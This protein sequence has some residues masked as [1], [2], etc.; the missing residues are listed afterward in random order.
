[1]SKTMREVGIYRKRFPRVS[2]TFITEPAL[3]LS[4][5]DPIFIA[6]TLLKEVAFRNISI[7]Q[8]DFLNIKQL[9][10][11]ITRSPHLFGHSGLLNNLDLIHAHFGP[12]GVYAMALAEKLKIPLI[13]SFWGYDITINRRKIWSYGAPLY[14]QLILHEKELKEKASA[15]LVLSN[16]LRKKLIEQGYPEKKI[17]LYNPGINIRKFSPRTEEA[18]E[19]FILC[20]G[21][22]TEKKGID[23]LLR[24]FARIYKKHPNVSLIQ[25]G[26]G[27][28]TAE[29]HALSQKLGISQYVRFVGA[30]PHDEVQ[31]L[32]RNA[33]IFALP[34]QMAENGDCEGMPFAILEACASGIPVVSTWHS[35]IPEAIL[36]GETGFLVSEKDD[37]ALAEKLDILLSDRALSKQMGQRGR[38]YVCELFDI[39]KQT[40][41]LEAIYDSVL[42]IK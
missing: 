2:E 16:F 36:D 23:T 42:G 28:L 33:E 19:R 6:C 26:A 8:S 30:K 24:A 18:D 12:D 35:G 13:V 41:K 14:Y 25:V 31:K 39:H 7:N 10:Y 37:V 38:E 4:K 5:Y 27:D 29:L 22:H 17:I 11:L 20:V 34:S 3:N 40:I 32:M 1:M 9:I 21:R 15:F